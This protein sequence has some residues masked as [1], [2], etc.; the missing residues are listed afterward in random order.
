MAATIDPITTYAEELVKQGG[1]KHLS[2]DYREK[3]V[4]QIAEQAQN[5]LGLMALSNLD[6]AK[7]ETFAALAE[8]NPPQGEI[9]KFF[10]ENIK[11]FDAK[12]QQSLEEFGADFIRRSKMLDKQNPA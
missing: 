8:K 11:D 7:M 5:K 2:P 1:F 9:L 4:A 6:Q 12:M 3:F 10:R